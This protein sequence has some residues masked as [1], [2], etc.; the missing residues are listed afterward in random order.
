M[1]YSYFIEQFANKCCL[2]LCQLLDRSLCFLYCSNASL[3]FVWAIH[4]S[5]IV[6]LDLLK[7]SIFY[8][9]AYSDLFKNWSFYL[10]L[11]VISIIDYQTLYII[12]LLLLSNHQSNRLVD[13]NLDFDLFFNL[14]SFFNFVEIIAYLVWVWAFL[15]FCK[16]HNDLKKMD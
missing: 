9:L 2:K 4:M 16:M 10:S 13:E 1:S 12:F 5:M 3:C 6:S 15:F 7:L 14:F 11:W 8:I